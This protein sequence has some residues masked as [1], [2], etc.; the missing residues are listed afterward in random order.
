MLLLLLLLLLLLKVQCSSSFASAKSKQQTKATNHQPT[1]LMKFSNKPTKLYI[2]FKYILT[3]KWVAA[4]Q[5]S[6]L[7][8]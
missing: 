1:K 6:G 4:M 3:E 7:G 8:F 2:I 5:F